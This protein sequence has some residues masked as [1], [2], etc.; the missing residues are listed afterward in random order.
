MRVVQSSVGPDRTD[1]G[2]QRHGE[3]RVGEGE[4]ARETRTTWG[5]REGGREGA[6]DVLFDSWANRQFNFSLFYQ[7]IFV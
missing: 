7:L 1:G 5:G 3:W 4:R 6:D 2:W